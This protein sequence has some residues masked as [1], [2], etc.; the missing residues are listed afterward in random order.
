MSFQ[1]NFSGKQ[2]NH[3]EPVE[4]NN[5]IQ[6]FTCEEV[7]PDQ[8]MI[9]KLDDHVKQARMFTC[10]DVEIGHVVVS[11]AISNMSSK[12]LQMASKLIIDVKSDLITGQYEGGL[13]IW[14]CTSDLIQYLIHNENKINFININVLDLGCGAGILGIYSFLKGA[15]VTFQDYN[16]EV[17]QYVTIPNVLLNIEDEE[18]RNERVKKCFFYSGDWASFN[19]T[20]DKTTSYDLILTSETI[21]NETNYGKLIKLFEQRLTANGSI[22]VAAKTCYFGVGGGIRQ[23]EKAIIESSL[24]QCEVTWKTTSGIQREIL[25]ITKK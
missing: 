23:F 13:K 9:Q 18:E 17:L 25:K 6:W 10:G 3:N 8:Q 22:Y 7:V 2:D 1:F 24:F 14:E 21:Y 20:L 5:E 16:K 12:S 15:N 4:T 19:K 11:D